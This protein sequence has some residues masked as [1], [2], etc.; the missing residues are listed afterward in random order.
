[1]RI[2]TK[3]VTDIESGVVLERESFDYPDT[4]PIEECSKAVEGAV[5]LAGA[6]VLG[7]ATLG[8]GFFAG[9]ALEAA[10][11][12]STL[13]TS[14][15][16]GLAA[17]GAAMEAGAIAQALTS[18][19]GE[20][21][22]TRQA[23]AFRQIIYGQQRVGGIEIWRSSTGG[24]HDQL[25][26]VIVLAGHECD[27]IQ[28]LYLDGRQVHWA[29]PGDVGNVTR[30]G[31]NFGGN[32]DG[33]TYT[34][35]DGNRYNFGGKVYCHATYGDQTD[36]TV[37]QGLTA[38][39][40]KWAADGQ[41][42]SPWVAGCCY[43]YLKIEYD[44]A[45]F[46]N[47]PEIRFTV[48]GKN[49]I[50]DPR[51]Q[52]TG[53]TSNWAL[54]AADVITDPVYGLGS[55]NVNQAQLIAAA[56]VCDEQVA[57]AVAPGNLTEK[58]YTTNY[59]YDTSSSPH[60]VL[61]NMMAGA[62]GRMSLIGGQ[63]Y[64]FP[65]YFQGASAT[66]GASNLTAGFK[67]DGY[68]S[69][70]DLINCVN[71]TYI[72]PTFPYNITG[73]LYDKNGWY[74]GTL[75]NNFPFA[76]QPTNFPQYADD[77]LHGFPAGTNEWLTQDGGIVHP[78]ELTLG[79]VLSVTQ[80][81]RVAAIVLRRNR[82][83]GSTTLEMGLAAYGLQP[84]DTFQ[85]NFPKMNWVN[86]LLEVNGT[87][88]HVDNDDTSGA[89]V[90]RYGVSV[91]ETDPTVYE[92]VAASQEL[93]VYAV[94]ASPSQTPRVPAPPT[95]LQL[96]SGPNVSQVNPDGTVNN[97]IVVEWD[98]PLDFL[99]TSININF[100]V[101][102]T[103]A[104]LP[105]IG[106]SVTQN[107]QWISNVVPGQFYDIQINSQ[108]ANGN[109]S[110]WV[111]QLNYQVS[112]TPTFLGTLA[113]QIPAITAGSLLGGT[114][115]GEMLTNSNFASG[116]TG[117]TTGLGTATIDTAQ[118]KVGSQSCRFQDTIIAQTVNLLAGHTY[119]FQTWI[120]CDGS[121]LASGSLGA[122]LYIFDPSSHLTVQKVNGTAENS[123]NTF[124]GV[125]LSA[126][127]ATSWTL[128]QITFSCAVSGAYSVNLTDCYG[129]TPSGFTTHTWMSGVSLTD[130]TGG[131]DVTGSQPIVYTA[132]GSSIVPNGT[133]VLGNLQGWQVSQMAYGTDTHGPR[134]FG[135]G[136]V[137]AFAF[138]PAF[139]V[140]PGAKYRLFYTM[141]NGSG[142][143]GIFLRVAWQSTA[144]TSNVIP[145]GSPTTVPGFQDF[146]ANGSVTTT[147]TTYAFDW[148]APAGALYASMCVYAVGAS[149]LATQ[150]V[151]C[152]PY[153]ATGQWGSDV[154]GSNTSND[155]SHVAGVASSVIASVV[156]SGFKLEI[157]SGA[158]LYSLTAI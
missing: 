92:W 156:P 67:W 5:L 135:T 117:W 46:P 32:A 140:N 158:R 149:D 71:G 61:Q 137:G 75:Q 96:F 12:S 93:T 58:R 108:R 85:M 43:V 56:N 72:A 6:A 48:N 86:K 111:Q 110:T 27:S 53:F 151:A 155:T 69:V 68:R 113:A 41:G 47:E 157:N 9:T 90:I 22:T 55:N 30:N 133:F 122:G 14:A 124:P 146:L 77:H 81:Q 129:V 45:T 76:F 13:T 148:T 44:Q 82:Q 105:S 95:N 144:T 132:T 109:Q 118:H 39:D 21:L 33:N 66:F 143:G 28:N 103:T 18:T 35:P 107:A 11:A 1:M 147:P 57:L 80:A 7:A 24:K 23:A 136:N 154:T 94:A 64:L 4:A 138:S 70:R 17:G 73:N 49:N 104:W 88:I 34:G 131:A 36:G 10:L 59:H 26:Y 15:I 153:A 37:D 2:N 52:T 40:P 38:N 97:L 119:L 51:T 123:A 20:S 125:V 142:A 120:M 3:V 16:I 50:W 112:L 130:T 106:A 83:Q 42:N 8:V 65:A 63:Y 99:A 139:Q 134:M 25:N 114:A 141:Y 79:T 126:S 19:K 102:G 31:V 29:G 62:A 87:A 115:P 121:T 98:T 116:L 150:S 89:Q 60:D 152:I 84:C 127:A 78:L 128:L 101:S 91:Q 54:C 74:N 100:R 145:T